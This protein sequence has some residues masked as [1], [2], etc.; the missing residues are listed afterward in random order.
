MLRSAGLSVMRCKPDF[1]VPRFRSI[2]SAQMSFLISRFVNAKAFPDAQEGSTSFP[3]PTASALNLPWTR[4]VACESAISQIFDV[5]P[6]PLIQDEKITLLFG[7]NQQLGLGR[8]GCVSGQFPTEVLAANPART[9][10]SYAP[11]FVAGPPS[12]G[13]SHQS[14]E[15]LS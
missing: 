7:P 5:W 3:A 11:V 4:P 15:D 13:A 12:T 2:A 10:A 1:G 9:Q 14:V 6:L 8:S